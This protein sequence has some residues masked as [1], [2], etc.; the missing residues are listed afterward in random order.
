MRTMHPVRAI[1]IP[2]EQSLS[3]SHSHTPLDAL[4]SHGRCIPAQQS[5]LKSSCRCS[6]GWGGFACASPIHNISAAA[7]SSAAGA[8]IPLALPARSWAYFYLQ[9]GLDVCSAASGLGQCRDTA[10]CKD[11]YRTHFFQLVPRNQDLCL[12]LLCPVSN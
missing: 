7:A 3:V 2:L 1:C 8:L 9:V 4:C 10:A 5:W 11:P 6:P 12:F